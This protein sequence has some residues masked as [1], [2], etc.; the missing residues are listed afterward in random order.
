MT[1]N[2]ADIKAAIDN[3]LQQLATTQSAW[4]RLQRQLEQTG[5]PS[6]WLDPAILK[7]R[8]TVA[9]LD[10]ELQAFGPIPPTTPPFDLASIAQGEAEMARGEGIEAGEVLER[11]IQTG[12]W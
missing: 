2:P 1:T 8:E 3:L 4:E 9:L 6:A 7:A 11:F 12:T 5:A 10:R